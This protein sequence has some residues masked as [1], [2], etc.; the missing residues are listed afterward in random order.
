MIFIQRE[1]ATVD[2]GAK[3]EVGGE[4]GKNT[5]EDATHNGAN[6]GSRGGGAFSVGWGAGFCHYSPTR[7]SDGIGD[8]FACGQGTGGG[9]LSWCGYSCAASAF[10]SD[11]RLYGD[12][13]LVAIATTQ[14]RWVLG[15]SCLLILGIPSRGGIEVV[16]PSKSRRVEDVET[17]IAAAREV[18][19]IA[20]YNDDLAVPDVASMTNTGHR[21]G[22]ASGVDLDPGE[23]GDGEDPHV[24]KL[25]LVQVWDEVLATVHVDVGAGAVR[26]RGSYCARIDSEGRIRACSTLL[27]PG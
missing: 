3:G 16:A 20:A 25:C 5:R 27:V 1:L 4:D 10:A 21:D 14:C 23:A 8:G 19:I 12:G 13:D 17:A 6:V 11:D 24:A 2:P 18:G 9:R 26:S 22:L 7:P 15:L